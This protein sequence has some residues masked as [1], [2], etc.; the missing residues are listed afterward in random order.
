MDA[1]DGDKKVALEEEQSPIEQVAL[2]VFVTD[3]PSLPV[4][5]FRVWVLG[6][7]LCVLP[8]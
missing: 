1:Y 5:T 2:V 8:K 4:F 6:C 7:M 3:D